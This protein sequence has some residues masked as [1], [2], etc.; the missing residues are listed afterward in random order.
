MPIIEDIIAA[1]AS[2]I[3]PPEP[4]ANMNLAEVKENTG[5]EFV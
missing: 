1:G 2:G 5:T 3:H 4:A